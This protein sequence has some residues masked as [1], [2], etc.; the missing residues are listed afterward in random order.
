MC[1]CERAG[2]EMRLVIVARLGGP[3]ADV[4]HHRG[5]GAGAVRRRAD[6]RRLAVDEGGVAALL[7]SCTR[8]AAPSRSSSWAQPRVAIARAENAYKAAEGNGRLRNA[9]CLSMRPPGD[10]S[11][12]EAK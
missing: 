10:G 7:S 12:L 5:D 2:P 11:L 9:R 1:R 6:Q 8:V 4:E 3:P